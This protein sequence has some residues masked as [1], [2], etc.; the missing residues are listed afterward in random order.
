MKY[1]QYAAN[2]N[3]PPAA[4]Q[5]K[6]NALYQAMKGAGTDEKAIKKCLTQCKLQWIYCYLQR[7]WQARTWRAIILIRQWQLRRP[8]KFLAWRFKRK[9]FARFAPHYGS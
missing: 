1:N 2:S 8:Y 6:A 9:R 3:V 4:A 5:A 7:F